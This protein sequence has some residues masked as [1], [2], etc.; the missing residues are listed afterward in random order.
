MGKKGEILSAVEPEKSSS[1]GMF[2]GVAIATIVAV[3]AG[4]GIGFQFSSMVPP[5]A[6]KEKQEKK[7]TSKPIAETYIDERSV[8]SL[9]AIVTNLAGPKGAWVRM[10][11][12]IIVKGTE[13]GIEVLAAEIAEDTLAYLRTLTLSD[14]EGASG[15]AYLRGD[16]NERAVIRSEGKVLEFVIGTLVVE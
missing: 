9:P 5:P 13:E 2:A 7:T 14:L 1:K 15:L 10:E 4:A 8:K 12:S 6:P 16:L 11:A 3:S